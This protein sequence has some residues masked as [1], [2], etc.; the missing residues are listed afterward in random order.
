MTHSSTRRQFIL[1]GVAVAGGIVGHAALKQQGTE[2]AATSNIQ[3]PTTE[4]LPQRIL[5]KTGL[6]VPIFGLGGAGQTPLSKRGQEAEAVAQIEAALNLGIRYYDT[7]ASYGPSEDNLGKVLPPYRS[8]VM[9]AT[10]TAQRDRD[11]AWREL[12]RSLQRLNTDYL[13][14][15]QLHHVSFHEELDQ[16]F[17]NTGAVKAIEEAKEQGI[18]K[19]SGITGHHE[20]DVIAA[21][22]QRYPFDTTLIALNA[23]DPHHPRPFASTVLPVA[24]QQ[25]IGVI[26]MKIPA[27]GRLF[28][29]GVLDNMEQAMGYVLSLAGV[30]C[31]IIAAESVEQL[32]ANFK[33]A[34]QFQPLN[35][36]QM[37]AIKA[38]TAQAWQEN[39]FFRAWT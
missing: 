24:Q 3:P 8:Q 17:S 15:W 38:R 18:I 11:G 39:T 25:N 2:I 4:T 33:V 27:Y 26:A 5:G 16:I 29:N 35:T 37:A 34:Q 7:A 31:C 12:E 23:A 28:R 20:P 30:H 32:T 19:Y 22:L 9:I 21:G 10:K 13:D 36:E 6:N 14:L 1:T